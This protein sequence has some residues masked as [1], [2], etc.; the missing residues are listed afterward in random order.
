MISTMT[1]PNHLDDSAA[2]RAV[3]YLVAAIL[4]IVVFTVVGL[5]LNAELSEQAKLQA[6]PVNTETKQHPSFPPSRPRFW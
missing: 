6:Q 2:L 5:M 3:M 1:D 4:L